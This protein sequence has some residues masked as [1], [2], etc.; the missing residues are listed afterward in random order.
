MSV[1]EHVKWLGSTL[2]KILK[3]MVLFD[4]AV[5]IIFK[6]FYIKNILMLIY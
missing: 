5:T 3:I 6:L 4:I 2:F 1:C